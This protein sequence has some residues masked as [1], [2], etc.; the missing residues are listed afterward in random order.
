MQSTKNQAT[1]LTV[2]ILRADLGPE[3]PMAESCI[4]EGSL[5]VCPLIFDSKNRV[6]K[7]DDMYM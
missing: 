4:P 3:T 2:S 1:V 6:M 7:I 5:S